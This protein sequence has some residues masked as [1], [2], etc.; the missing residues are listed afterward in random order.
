MNGADFVKGQAVAPGALVSIFGTKLANSVATPDTIPL[1]TT[2]GGVTVKFVNGSNSIDAP[3]LYVNS[4]Q[5]N[6]VVPWHLLSGSTA[7]KVDVVVSNNGAASAP[8]SLNAESFSPGV[9]AI[10]SL[11]A[12]QNVDGSLAQP[13]G[14][15]PGRA[16]HPAPVGSVVVIYTTGLG[17]VNPA[18]PDGAIPPHGTLAHTLH[19]PFVSIGGHSAQ[20]VFSG[21]SPQFVG[22]YQLNVTI[23]AIAP[24]ESVP[25]ELILG[26]V[27]S[28]TGITMAVS[29]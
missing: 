5:I 22:V 19:T 25:V 17:P 23:P 15:I 10:G 9:I 3:L 21:L 26:G 2:L 14:S 16:T 11:A 1:S 8:F 7:A 6:A 24:G 28:A 20:V 13:P 29:Q 27:K 4:S 18:V 12:V